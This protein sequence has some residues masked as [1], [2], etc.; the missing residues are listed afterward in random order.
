MIKPRKHEIAGRNQK[1]NK[2]IK[3]I[4]LEYNDQGLYKESMDFLSQVIIHNKT[5][6][7]VYLNSNCLGKIPKISKYL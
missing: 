6:K 2:T 5:I 3:L 7:S 1:N 4:N